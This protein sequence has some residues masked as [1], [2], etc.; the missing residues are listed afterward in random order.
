MQEIYRRFLHIILD[1]MIIYIIHKQSKVGKK[2]RK[3]LRLQYYTPFCYECG[4]AGVSSQVIG[5]S[6]GVHS[7]NTP[8]EGRSAGGG[9]R[10]ATVINRVVLCKGQTTK[11]FPVMQ[12]Y[13]VY[14]VYCLV[15][16]ILVIEGKCSVT[17]FVQIVCGVNCNE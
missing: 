14:H 13:I 9:T 11:L 4:S 12:C 16:M 2:D 5:P 10:G 6:L 15:N 7:G 1:L 8:L 3:S 17:T